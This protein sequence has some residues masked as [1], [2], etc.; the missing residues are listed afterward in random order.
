MV[1]RFYFVV[2]CGFLAGYEPNFYGYMVGKELPSRAKAYFGDG[3]HYSNIPETYS[4][5]CRSLADQ[6]AFEPEEVAE[7]LADHLDE[8]VQGQD[9]AIDMIATGGPRTRTRDQAVRES[10]AWPIAFSDEGKKKAAEAGWSGGSPTDYA[11]WIE[12]HCTLPLRADPIARWRMRARLLREETNPHDAL[13]RYR[14]F[15]D[16]TARPRGIL[17]DAHAQVEAYIDEQIQLAREE[18]HWGR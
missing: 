14:E 13:R 16:S 5:G 6:L 3:P 18:G 2:A 15:M 7:G 11:K 8:V 12:S 10:M 9:T 1:S 4:E 17:D